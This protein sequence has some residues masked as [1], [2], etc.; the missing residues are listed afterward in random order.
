[1]AK[2]TVSKNNNLSE[3]KKANDILDDE[4]LNDLKE[5]GNEDV[6]EVSRV[7]LTSEELSDENLLLGDEKEKNTGEDKVEA[8]SD[9]QIVKTI[10]WII[11]LFIALGVGVYFVTNSSARTPE[12]F[13]TYNGY[14]FYPQGVLWKTTVTQPRSGGD[15][16]ITLHYTPRDLQ[17]IPRASNLSKFI[18][19][20]LGFTGKEG[21]Q[22]AAFIQ[23]SPEG[24]GT[25]A[26]AASEVY[27]GLRQ[28]LGIS[29]YPAYS[30]NASVYSEVP[31][32]LCNETNEPIIVLQTGDVNQITYPQPN[33]L[34][35]QGETED[36][37]VK[38][39][40]LLLYILY[41]VVDDNGSGESIISGSS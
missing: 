31:V 35:V 34:I 6:K 10:A 23:Y 21:Y 16:L 3:D 36:D 5:T 13:H 15:I 20:S 22:G 2:K 40:N 25:L 27:F 33:C 12:G 41:G 14:D 11:V 8:S 26:V 18:D 17:N 9:S 30:H 28:V 4:V 7:E 32:K 29:S 37:I 38:A 19:Y 1:M 39:E 24:S